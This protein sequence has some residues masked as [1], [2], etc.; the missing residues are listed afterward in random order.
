[1]TFLDSSQ[2]QI[3]ERVKVRILAQDN[4]PINLRIKEAILIK[5]KHP[6]LNSREEIRELQMLT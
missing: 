4:D 1:M 5:E 6:T 2:I 3:Q